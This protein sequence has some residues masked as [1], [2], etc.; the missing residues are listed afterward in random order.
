MCLSRLFVIMVALIS[1]GCQKGYPTLEPSDPKEFHILAETQRFAGMLGK[2]IRGEITDER[3][4]VPS[5]P[6]PR[7][8]V[9]AAG[10]Y[11]NGTCY[12]WRKIVLERDEA[13]G[14]ALARHEVC[15]S[16][17]REHKSKEFLECESSLR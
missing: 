16:V 10:W 11:V 3:Y 2:K 14:T 8:Y 13:Y 7:L 5:D 1:L 17:A 6:D 4:M 15:H 9:P 12:Y